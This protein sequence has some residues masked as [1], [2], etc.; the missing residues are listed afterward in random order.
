MKH[1]EFFSDRTNGS[2]LIVNIDGKFSSFD[3]NHEII[4]V[5]FDLLK[6]N[7]SKAF[8]ELHTI[9]GGAAHFKYL[10]VRRFL[11]C[12]FMVH[13]HHPDITDNIF[14]TE[15]V[16]CPLRGECRQEGIVCHPKLDTVLSAREE[17][18]TLLIISGNSDRDIA[19]KLFISIYT[20]K[21]HHR[22]ILC[23]LNCTTAELSAKF[24][25]T[26]PT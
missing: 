10:M 7:Y 23:K 22:N 13:D 25:A 20:A 8:K 12:N 24:Q 26:N 6:N 1:I 5:V 16:D 3:E 19:E 17:E 9:Y 15:M 14:R 2:D 21:N 18:I 4:S 11:K